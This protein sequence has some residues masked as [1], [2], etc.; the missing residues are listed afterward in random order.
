M[1]IKPCASHSKLCYSVIYCYHYKHTYN[2]ITSEYKF[3]TEEHIAM[4]TINLYTDMWSRALMVN[5][6]K[7]LK[8]KGHYNYSSFVI[9]GHYKNNLHMLWVINLKY[10]DHTV[11]Y[12]HCIINMLV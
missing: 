9:T 6:S 12:G 3:I 1:I 11:L 4:H 8:P 7:H 2:Y 5:C 10:K